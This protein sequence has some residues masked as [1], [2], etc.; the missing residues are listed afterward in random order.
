MQTQNAAD[1][2]LVFGALDYE[3]RRGILRVLN[4]PMDAVS[5]F[6]RVREM[7]L[8][9]RHRETVY[10]NL[11]ILAAAKIVYKRNSG[12]GNR[13]VTYE[14]QPGRIFV[15]PYDMSAALENNP[16]GEIAGDRLEGERADLVFKAMNNGTRRKMMKILLEGN[17]HP[18]K[19]KERLAY[20]GTEF[21]CKE[22]VFDNLRMLRNAEL[23]YRRSNGAG[24]SMYYGSDVKQIAIDTRPLSVTL[25]RQARI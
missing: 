19:I 15:D 24:S 4:G 25:L 21:R 20:L 7:G 2:G 23:V 12:S 6:E 9:A 22:S 8:R 3:L 14:L 11:E 18:N 17:M 16:P 10:K 13:D 1:S 5:V